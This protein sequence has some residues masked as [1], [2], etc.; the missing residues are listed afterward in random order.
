M[1]SEY[2]CLPCIQTDVRSLGITKEGNKRQ[3]A[4]HSANL[5]A[6]EIMAIGRNRS[7]EMV[8]VVY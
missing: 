6:Q 4:A 2:I 1:L 3:M 8:E 5:N 7:R